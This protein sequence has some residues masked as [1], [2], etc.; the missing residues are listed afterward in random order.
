VEVAREAG[1]GEAGAHHEPPAPLRRTTTTAAAVANTSAT[2]PGATQPGSPECVGSTG[3]G[4]DAAAAWLA[5]E[6]A[7]EELWW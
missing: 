1:D 3:S 4:V 7:A 6:G 5:G 2:S